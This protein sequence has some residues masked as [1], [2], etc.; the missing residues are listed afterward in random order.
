M[1]ITFGPCRIWIGKRP[2]PFMNITGDHGLHSPGV[3]GLARRRDSTAP[4]S[5]NCGAGKGTFRKRG[6]ASVTPPSPIHTPQMSGMDGA[7]LDEMADDPH[8]RA[9]SAYMMLAHP[10]SD[11]RRTFS[12]F[13]FRRCRMLPRTIAR[14]GLRRS[15]R[16]CL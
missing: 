7:G 4:H 5:V 16:E 15:G 12:L 6:S 3:F 1:T 11:R 13:V 2:A 9:A 8:A 10:R 14:A